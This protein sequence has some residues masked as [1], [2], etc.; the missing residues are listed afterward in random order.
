VPQLFGLV[1][2]KEKIIIKKDHLSGWLNIGGGSWGLRNND[3]TQLLGNGDD[4]AEA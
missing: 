4:Y 2:K 3:R 1:K